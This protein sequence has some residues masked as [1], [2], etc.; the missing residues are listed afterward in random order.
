MGQLCDAG[1]IVTFDAENVTVKYN[2]LVVLDGHR[3]PETLLW[4]LNLTPVHPQAMHQANG[5]I[6]S[7]TPAE[8]VTFAH[9]T[10][11]SPALST[12]QKALDKGYISNFPGLTTSSL[13]KYPPRSI[14][15]V[16]G[17][18]K[19]TRQNQRSTKAKTTKSPPAPFPS[20]PILL[21]DA[22]PKSETPNVKT[23]KCYTG[24]METTGQ[25]YS[26]Q[27]GRFVVPSNTGNNY[28]LIVYDYDS[29]AILAEP[30]RTR[31]SASIITAY[32][33]VHARLC[34]AG[35][36]PKLQRLD[37]ECSEEFKELLHKEGIDF[38][39]VPPGSH[40]RNA[41]ERAIQTFKDHFIAGL[42]SLDKDFPLHLWDK[43]LLQAELTLNLLRGSRTQP[44]LSSYAAM[45]GFFDFNRTP[46][47]PP[48]IR[49]M[50]HEKPANR[51]TWSPSALDGFKQY[52]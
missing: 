42:C 46:L 43:L 5:A 40:R 7:A 23:H 26:D 47:A 50:A 6:G 22:F 13:R 9:A 4:K 20:D 19:Q 31:T 32:K 2:N 15:M 51:T 48:G 27:T 17:H 14:P 30:M 29:N 41:A 25:I 12:L 35:F 34:K 44:H 37:N 11:F 36:R 24:V 8:L 1:C 16:K 28:L 10:L 39:L 21:D 45:K 33:T 52:L 49:V 38:Q 3:T 18:L